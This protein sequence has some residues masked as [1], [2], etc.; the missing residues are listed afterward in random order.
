MISC[1]R[2]LFDIPE[3]IAYLNTA[4]MS[5]L[6]HSV[7]SAVDK[8]VRMKATPWKL[9]I[10]DFYDTVDKA[11]ALFS[12]IV[13]ADVGGVAI[14]PS[15]S[16]GI[17]TAVKNLRMDPGKTIVTLED[18][19]PSNIYPWQR[20]V[21]DQGGEIISVTLTSVESATDAV[22]E[23]MDDRCTIVALPNVLWTNGLYIDLVEIRRKCDQFGAALVLDLT[24][25]VG[26]MRTDFS[27]IRPDFAV[28]AGYKWLLCPY[29]TGFLYV[30]SKWRSGEPLEAGWITRRDSRNFSGLVS[31]TDLYEHGAIRYD[32]GERA[33]FSLMPGVV[34]ALRQLL[35]WGVDNIE[36]T[37]AN[38]S[39]QLAER[40]EAIGLLTPPKEF[41]GP[42]FIGAK[43]P[44]SA[45]KDLLLKLSSQ[46][47]FLS[48]RGG[49]L[50]ITPHLWNSD[51]DF[52]KL[53]DV[54]D[55]EF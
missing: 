22:V 13:N 31:Y 34:V 23:A 42:H 55:R 36:D 39:H 11:R 9:T 15:A 29:S 12:E 16:Y 6:M 1:Q 28:V 18:Q 4:Y 25:S 32:V 14:V 46:N 2:H 50:R 48:E 26:A 3:D 40:L 41:R 53:I 10:A 5:P 54:L 38:N 52:D 24:Q 35:D 49:A 45:P 19:F 51:M 30:D 21:R 44:K 27:K 17:E 43:L 47:V 20:M 33:N 8:G 37:L 7:I